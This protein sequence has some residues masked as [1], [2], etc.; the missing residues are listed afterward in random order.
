[1]SKYKLKL[2]GLA[3]T[4][5]I[6]VSVTSGCSTGSSGEQVVGR[7]GSPFWFRTASMQTRID[8]YKPGCLG[9]G[10][11]D[12]T[13]EMAQCLQSAMQSQQSSNS[14]RRKPISCTT[15]GNRTSCY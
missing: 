9:Y 13:P 5:G 14:N 11:T 7:P 3:L 10:F 2:A 1:M 4:A 12:G 8:Y 15:Y 6:V